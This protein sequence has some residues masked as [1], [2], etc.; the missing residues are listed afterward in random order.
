MVGGAVRDYELGFIAFDDSTYVAVKSV[1]PV[2]KDEI[3]TVF[4]GE[5]DVDEYLDERLWHG[6]CSSPSATDVFSSLPKGL[7]RLDLR[8]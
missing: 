5:D 7:A 1:L 8:L 2:W 4:R 3:R 6:R